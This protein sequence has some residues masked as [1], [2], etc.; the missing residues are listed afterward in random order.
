MGIEKSALRHA[1]WEAHGHGTMDVS[2]LSRG[3][4]RWF[5]HMFVS[6]EFHVE[7]C[8]YLQQL[9]GPGCSDHSA[10]SASLTFED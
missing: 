9:M 2:H 3:Q 4:K 8:D 1:Y 6:E 5:D 7:Q 10:L